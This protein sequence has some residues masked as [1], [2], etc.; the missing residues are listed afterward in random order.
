[1][2]VT[3]KGPI[4][5]KRE[6]ATIREA[7]EFLNI[8]EAA[9]KERLIVANIWT[10]AD[11]GKV[12]RREHDGAICLITRIDKDRD[13]HFVFIDASGAPATSYAKHRR[14]FT[15][16]SDEEMAAGFALPTAGREVEVSHDRGDPMAGRLRALLRNGDLQIVQSEIGMDGG[17]RIQAVGR[18]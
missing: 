14:H 17:V 2:S 13:A 9:E 7:V 11:I 10:E 18:F 12:F 6:I 8:T 16:L 3:V 1:M 15:A 4:A 5:D